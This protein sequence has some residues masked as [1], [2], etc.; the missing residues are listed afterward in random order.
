M[1]LSKAIRFSSLVSQLSPSE[2]VSFIKDIA[3]SNQQI[4]I[5]ALSSYFLNVPP[6]DERGTLNDQYIK[7]ISSIIQSRDS[8]TDER[9]SI[10]FDSLPRRLIG[11]CASFLEQ[12]S[13]QWLSRVNRAV[14]L[15]C[16]TP[17]VLTEVEKHYNFAD[18]HRLFNF[19]AFPFVKRLILKN[20][21]DFDLSVL[22]V[23]KMNVIASQI[24]KM[25]QLQ[26]LELVEV[27]PE[28]IGIIA[29]HEE[30][31]RRTKCLHV[32]RQQTGHGALERFFTSITSFKHIQFLK[33]NVL[34]IRNEDPVEMDIK[35]IIE[36][37]SNLKGLDFY[38]SRLG[39]E[40]AILPSIGH[41]LH[42]L[43][44][45]DLDDVANS[46]LKD[47]NFA[48]LRQLVQEKQC[49]DDS[50]KCILKTAI[51]LEKVKFHAKA[52]ISEILTQCERLKYLE[53][54]CDEDSMGNV[55][56]MIAL[57]FEQKNNA[58][59]QTLKIRIHLCLNDSLS[60]AQETKA[61]SN[62]QRVV[63]SLSASKLDQWMIILDLYT[64]R[65]GFPI[66]M[67]YKRIRRKLNRNSDVSRNY[68]IDNVFVV[69][70]L[71]CTIDGIAEKWLM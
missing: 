41:Q 67:L 38:D 37:C 69:T 26:S 22:S 43:T 48:N 21:T 16:N 54:E 15:G 40:M 70:N 61:V 17:I 45:Y 11:V 66:S 23:E 34:M 12:K 58:L 8:Q 68:Q 36:M 4:I 44:F 50:F 65:A 30:T 42:Y 52:V 62:L 33:M 53:I 31:N 2:T 32:E 28:F 27:D 14:Y 19:S 25:S 39:I 59:K 49:S 29:Y 63:N 64:H 5:D 9:S 60:R 56:D 71:D 46:A 3:D 24:A 55:L 47:V 35:P 6:D 10:T 57:F 1:P 7:S 13:F 18:E 51:N 20:D